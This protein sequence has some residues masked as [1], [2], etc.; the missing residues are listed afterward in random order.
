MPY[1][2]RNTGKFISNEQEFNLRAVYFQELP[3]INLQEINNMVGENED[4]P[5][6]DAPEPRYIMSFHIPPEKFSGAPNQHVQEWFS[7]FERIC[8]ANQHDAA[9]RMQILPALFV[10][11]AGRFYSSLPQAVTADYEALK[12]EFIREFGG[13]SDPLVLRY[14][15]N[16]RWQGKNEKVKDFARDLLSLAK[17]LF[18]LGADM[19]EDQRDTKLRLQFI[20]HALHPIKDA[21]LREEIQT[22]A[23]AVRIAKDA[24]SQSAILIGAVHESNP[25]LSIPSD[26]PS[27]TTVSA[28][29][30]S[31]LSGLREVQQSLAE[32]TKT[33]GQMTGVLNN[34]VTSQSSGR[35]RGSYAQGGF[36]GGFRGGARGGFGSSFQGN[37]H[38]C[39]RF[40]HRIAE[41]RIR[42]RDLQTGN[43]MGSGFHVD[44][45]NVSRSPPPSAPQ[46]IFLPPQSSSQVQGNM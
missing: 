21:L 17:K 11:E 1:R 42:M 36:R 29:A 14:R 39:S 37:C 32:V 5:F 31:Q 16:N 12:K 33:L 6:V 4:P 19:T 45:Q 3:E 43:A 25:A 38:Y 10:D 46:E 8:V 18:P 34:L 22:F 7:S 44:T 2:N 20:Q 24:E 27:S 40:G 15:W 9:K 41:C 23:E 13:E 26:V 28:V 30:Q 35:G